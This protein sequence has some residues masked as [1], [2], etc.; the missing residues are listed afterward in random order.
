MNISI[1]RDR[2]TQT[3]RHAGRLRHRQ[4][5]TGRDRD[6]VGLHRV[7]V[8]SQAHGELAGGYSGD[9]RRGRVWGMVREVWETEGQAPP[10][11]RTDG[12]TDTGRQR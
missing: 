6:V 9:S 11:G 3:N 7:V 12:Q 8:G 5:G 4:A 1:D 10:D 2:D